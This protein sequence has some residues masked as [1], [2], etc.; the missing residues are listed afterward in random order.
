MDATV[1]LIYNLQNRKYS[2]GMGKLETFLQKQQKRKNEV[3]EQIP[4]RWNFENL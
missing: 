3:F 4:Y 1:I 2:R